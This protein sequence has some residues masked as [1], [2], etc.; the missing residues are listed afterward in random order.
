[1]NSLGM[2]PCPG[3]ENVTLRRTMKLNP[4]LQSPHERARFRT[5]VGVLVSC[6][7][8]FAPQS[9]GPGAG[10]GS[11]EDGRSLSGGYGPLVGAAVQ[12]FALEPAID[13]VREGGRVLRLHVSHPERLL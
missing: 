6:G 3:R 7:L 2:F 12:D 11:G 4:D 5:L 8:T 10:V 13:Q 9:Y 1:M